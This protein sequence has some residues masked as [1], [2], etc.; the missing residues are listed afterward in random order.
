M[1]DSAILAWGHLATHASTRPAVERA[2]PVRRHGDPSPPV[3]V[4][5]AKPAVRLERRLLERDSG[6][7]RHGEA[8]APGPLQAMHDGGVRTRR[9]ATACRR[10]VAEGSTCRRLVR[11]P[12][13]H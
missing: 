12:L 2:P 8:T 13:V 4:V 10:Y 11:W 3:R 9:L 7:V 6:R 1:C 5:R